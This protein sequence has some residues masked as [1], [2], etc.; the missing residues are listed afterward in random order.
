MNISNMI[1]NAIF[2]SDEFVK[3]AGLWLGLKTDA[4]EIVGGNYSRVDVSNK[5]NHAENGMTSNSEQINFP[6]PSAGWGTVVTAVL[7]DAETDGNI[8]VEMPLQQAQTI[9][10]DTNV[11]YNENMLQFYIVSE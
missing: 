2:T 4:G 3:P 11:F 1:L 8:I 5:F 10:A 7:F 9:G 6:T